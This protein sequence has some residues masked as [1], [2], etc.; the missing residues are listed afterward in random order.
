[1][2]EGSEGKGKKGKESEGKGMEGKERGGK[3]YE[4]GIMSVDEFAF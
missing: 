3:D 4:T 2:I 1:M